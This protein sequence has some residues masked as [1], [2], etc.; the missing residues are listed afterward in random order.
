[1]TPVVNLRAGGSNLS[2]E[3]FHKFTKLFE[4]TP[5]EL[6]GKMLNEI[7]VLWHCPFKGKWRYVFNI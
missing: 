4:M 1:M 2:C 7:K 6:F 5:A 3:Y